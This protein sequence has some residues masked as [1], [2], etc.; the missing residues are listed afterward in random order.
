MKIVIFIILKIFFYYINNKE[1]FHDAYKNKSS[2]NENKIKF[3]NDVNVGFVIIFYYVM[4]NKM[5]EKLIYRICYKKFTFH[6]L[7]Y[8]HF[9]SKSYRRK[10]I[11]FEKLSK[12]KKI[13]YDLILTKKSFIIRK[14]KLIKLIT[15]F[16]L[17]NEI[18]FRF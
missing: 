16:I 14:L 6:N 13:T 8:T 12:D 9:K 17:S 4:M 18:S 11:R 15:S 7:L 5:S 10:I 3:K 2:K 1:Q